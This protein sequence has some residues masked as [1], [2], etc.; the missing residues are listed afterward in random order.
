MV[1]TFKNL[2]ELLYVQMVIYC[3][4]NHHPQ[5]APIA[6][7][8]GNYKQMLAILIKKELAQDHN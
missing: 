5:K 7:S 1:C 4:Y 6:R 3:R 8:H 2:M